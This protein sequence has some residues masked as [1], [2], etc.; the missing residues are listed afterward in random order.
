MF[1]TIYIQL[2][3]IVECV[4]VPLSIYFMYLCWTEEVKVLS[5]SPK[6]TRYKILVTFFLCRFIFVTPESTCVQYLYILGFFYHGWDLNTQPS[7]CGVNAL[8]HCD[9]AT[10]EVDVDE[11]LPREAHQGMFPDLFFQK[12][13]KSYFN[14]SLEQ[15]ILLNSSHNV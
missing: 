9:T 3:Y 5:T 10:V 15:I 11:K 8:T 1:S 6:K 14:K 12:S 13:L 7:A 4:F 2:V